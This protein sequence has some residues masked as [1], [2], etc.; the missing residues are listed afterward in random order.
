MNLVC[1]HECNEKAQKRNSVNASQATMEQPSRTIVHA[2]LEMTN[3]DSQEEVEADAV[4]NEIVQ[5]GKI[6]RS[7]FAGS[8]G[9]GMAVSSQMEGR[10]NS[11]QGGGQ[12][13]PDGLRNMME[14]GFNRDFS[15]V[16]VHTD[17]EAASLSSSIH[18]KAFTHGNDIYFN[19]GQFS[20]NTSEGQKLMAHELTH[21][22]Q[23]GSKVARE[24]FFY[25]GTGNDDQEFLK[26]ELK[27]LS[28]L[29]QK[30]IEEGNM[31][32]LRAIRGQ[33]L[34]L[35]N[36][37]QTD[38]FTTNNL[39]V[40]RKNFR[41]QKTGGNVHYIFAHG[42][43]YSFR[44][45]GREMGPK[46]I[47]EDFDSVIP[48]GNIKDGDTIVL[49]SCQTG[50]KVA[51]LLSKRFPRNLI[52]APKSDV[53]PISKDRKRVFT[54]DRDEDHNGPGFFMFL[55]GKQIDGITFDSFYDISEHK[56]YFSPTQN[57]GH[58][59]NLISNLNKNMP[60]VEDIEIPNW[61]PISVPS[62]YDTYPL[63]TVSPPSRKDLYGNDY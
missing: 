5:G 58:Y 22:V 53:A 63:K 61:D 8:A 41:H 31:Y 50:I 6:A 30:Y 35:Y 11:M 43:L 24:N 14:R 36:Q 10:L 56:D 18:A 48:S 21:V 62:P 28:Q 59:L 26:A 38:R 55:N 20:P 1:Q 4:A 29:R 13:M 27:R 32:A 23:G 16:R 60:D 39:G 46:E 47:V 15:Q 19:Q 49:M 34:S 17:S 9:G 52:V 54:V 37:L 12:V 45:N 3:P 25:N 40:I 51:E 42:S 7:I 57:I 2:K 33:Y 44:F